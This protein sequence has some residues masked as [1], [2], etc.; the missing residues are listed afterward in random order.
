MI[1]IKDLVKRY[2]ATYAIKG[3]NLNIEDSGIVGLVGPNGSGKTT[4]L[5]LIFGYCRPTHGE[6]KVDGKPPGVGIRSSVAFYS[7][8]D[9]TYPWMRARNLVKWY[10]S[11]FKDWNEEKEKKLIEFLELPMQRYVVHMSKGMR[12][13]LRLVLAL[14][15][16]TKLLLLD[17][18]L[19]DI[20]PLS[21]ERIISAILKSYGEEQ[22]IILS[23]HIVSEAETLFGR[24]IFLKQGSI[25]IDGEADDLREKYGKS[26][27]SIFKED[28]NG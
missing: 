27:D 1:E 24:T 16:N 17:E 23:T 4:L 9:S 11:F 8:V 7:E 28:L 2:G 21:R 18:P 5:K 25:I 12:A 19:S 14:S 26:I 15:R 3:I 6:I 13:R 20:D 10:S 22:T